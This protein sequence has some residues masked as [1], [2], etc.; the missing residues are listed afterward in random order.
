MDT[1]LEQTP[2]RRKNWRTFVRLVGFLKPYRL[3]L[4]VS[5]VLAVG[6]QAA[7]IAIILLSGAAIGAIKSGHHQELW[8]LIAWIVATGVARAL[9]MVA[10]RF[11]AGNQ[12]LGVEYDLRM[13]IYSKLVRLPFSFYDR[14]QTG[15]LMSRATVD[16]TA[17]RFFLGY[18]LVFFAQHLLT[19]VGVT[20]VM[21][22]LDW[23]LAL[24][25]LAVTPLIV[26]VAY[27]YSRVSHP[28]LRD[29][30]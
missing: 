26:V 8:T 27:V 29:L 10:R 18:G 28:L 15:Q 6:A 5:V 13:R 20:A 12:A 24:V 11:I 3:G 1:T 25:S 17:V 30:P 14:H 19:I 16:L 22:V 4:G 7:Q 21:L 9:F 23:R 2:A